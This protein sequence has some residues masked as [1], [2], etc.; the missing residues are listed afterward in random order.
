MAAHVKSAQAP[1]KK[2]LIL[3]KR[4]MRG[5]EELKSRNI[6][7]RNFDALSSQTWARPKLTKP[8]FNQFKLRKFKLKTLGKPMDYFRS[9][10]GDITLD[11]KF[12]SSL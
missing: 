8:T 4:K 6:T 2:S 11:S 5:L 1:S 10:Y 9:G 7:Q 12:S 3:H